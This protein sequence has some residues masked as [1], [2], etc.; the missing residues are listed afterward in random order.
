MLLGGISEMAS[1]LLLVVPQAPL[2]QQLTN[3]PKDTLT[4]LLYSELAVSGVVWRRNEGK[5]EER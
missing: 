2:L 1:E 3:L 5:V 4:Q